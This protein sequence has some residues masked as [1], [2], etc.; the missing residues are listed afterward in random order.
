MKQVHLI[1]SG[2]VQGVGYRSWF[3]REARKLKLTGW[4]FNRPDGTVA[5]VCVG[6]EP[7]LQ[8]VIQVAKNGPWMAAVDQVDVLWSEVTETNPDFTVKK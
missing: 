3:V 2:R 1:I 4:V 8:E 6:P 7:V 5:V